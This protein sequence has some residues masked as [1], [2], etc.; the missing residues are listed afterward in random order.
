[1]VEANDWTRIA[2]R[3]ADRVGEKSDARGT[4][5]LAVPS[6]DCLVL[7]RPI[8]PRI[9]LEAFAADGATLGQAVTRTGNE[10]VIDASDAI[11]DGAQTLRGVGPGKKPVVVLVHRPDEVARNVGGDRQRELR[12]ILGALDEDPAQLDALLK[13]TQKVIFDSDD[14][15]TSEPAIRRRTET[16]R[17]ESHEPG[18]ES[19]AVDALGRRAGRRK[20]R[21]ASGDI[22]VL[23]DAL[24]YRL[25]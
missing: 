21:L 17:E 25:G 23:L 7:E 5:V 4:V 3:Q 15:V 10:L 18:P 8:G 19:L 11:R 2:D 13:L 22:L 6:G 9:A 12:Q 20:R 14:I 1:S 16:T 24:M